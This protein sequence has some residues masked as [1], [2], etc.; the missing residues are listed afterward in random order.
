MTDGTNTANIQLLGDYTLS[1]FIASN[2]G[3]GGTSMVDPIANIGLL[4]NHM[5]SAFATGS[6]SLGGTPAPA[7]AQPDP[8]TLTQPQHG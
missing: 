6:D 8:V 5:A 2:D 7:S 3:F 4:A 1:T